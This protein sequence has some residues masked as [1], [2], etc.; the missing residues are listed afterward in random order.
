MEKAGEVWEGLNLLF[1]NRM[2]GYRTSGTVLEALGRCG[3]AVGLEGL[4]TRALRHF[5]ASVALQTG[6]NVVKVSQRL[7]YS[8]GSITSD[9]CAHLS[10]PMLR[11]AGSV[12]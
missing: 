9:I 10:T 7:G 3:E 8:R 4:T 11:L 2:G 12:R 1:P 6:R 5:H